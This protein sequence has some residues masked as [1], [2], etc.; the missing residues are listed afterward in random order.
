MYIIKFIK[1]SK[2]IV[3]IDNL[4]IILIKLEINGPIIHT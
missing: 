4:K 3:E 1:D 2:E